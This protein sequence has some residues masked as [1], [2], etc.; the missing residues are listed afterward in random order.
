MQHAN[1][2]FR[3]Q[4]TQLQIV[5]EET[6]LPRFRTRASSSESIESIVAPA[7][8]SQ[9]ICTWHSCQNATVE[10]AVGVPIRKGLLV[11]SIPALPSQTPMSQLKLSWK[12]IFDVTDVDGDRFEKMFNQGTAHGFM[13]SLGGRG[14]NAYTPKSLQPT[15][16]FY[17]R[18][19]RLL[20]DGM[21]DGKKFPFGFEA[22]F[23]E[24]AK[25]NLVC[26]LYA[27]T[28]FLHV[29]RSDLTFSDGRLIEVQKLPTHPE[30]HRLLLSVVEL[31]TGKPVQGPLKI[32]PCSWL[33]SEPEDNL[34]IDDLVEAATRHL[35]PNQYLV[36]N[37][38]KKNVS[39][40]I[41]A[42]DLILDRQGI[43]FSSPVLLAEQKTV[44]SRFAA[45]CAAL[46]V[47]AAC[48]RLIETG[49]NS[50]NALREREELRTLV[51]GSRE[52]YIH[53]VTSGNIWRILSDA[54][55]LNSREWKKGGDMMSEADTGGLLPRILIVTALDNEAAPVLNGLE[56][57]K[58]KDFGPLYVS[59]GQLVADKRVADVFVYVAGV[60]NVGVGIET[61][62]VVDAIQPDLT[63]FSG[64]AGGRKEAKI[65][66]VV[67]ASLVYNYESGKEA[68][69]L[70]GFF[71]KFYPRPRI[72]KPSRKAMSLINP[73]L[74]SYA[75]NEFS[76][77]LKP[78][79]CGEKVLAT[80]KGKIGELIFNVYSDALAVEME[81]FGFLS[82]LEGSS[83]MGILVRGISDRQDK[84]SDQEDHGS[85]T[86]NA[87]MV[88]LD[89]IRFFIR[90]R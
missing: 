44:Q 3:A 62:Q 21:F 25:V 81:G 50:P 32:Y 7:P 23:G 6:E 5:K 85:A 30:I 41:D 31:I 73:F 64:I 2:S 88:A 55:A 72:A 14:S 11:G 77:F 27:N 33:I 63:I 65:G 46:E 16:I 68:V 8:S 61:S 76:V 15:T 60:G 57:I 37:V 80:T 48:D 1:L 82:A 38:L 84:K 53:S 89:L 56:K 70:G 22:G 59:H 54:F 29:E 26:R 40:K 75:K 10:N 69:G 90:N 36:E 71:S 9:H 52:R 34:K 83:R 28:V 17:K 4:S 78:I 51:E 87:A 12:C 19:S 49:D 47:C 39:L 58:L 13:R 43:V 67:V 35:A 79:A 74:A 66:D 45:A 86:E 24:S 18:L 20:P 42:A